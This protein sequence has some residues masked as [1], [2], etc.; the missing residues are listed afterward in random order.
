LPAAA[1]LEKTL[2]DMVSFGFSHIFVSTSPRAEG[3]GAGGYEQLRKTSGKPYRPAF[4]RAG[5]PLV[6]TKILVRVGERGYPPAPPEK[7]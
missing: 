7:D 3:A 6:D 2:V 4:S 5:R 1:Q